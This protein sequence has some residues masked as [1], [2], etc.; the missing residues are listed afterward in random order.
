MQRHIKK[1]RNRLRNLPWCWFLSTISYAS[2]EAFNILHWCMSWVNV[3][4]SKIDFFRSLNFWQVFFFQYIE[5]QSLA[6][7]ASVCSDNTKD[8]CRAGRCSNSSRHCRLRIL[9][10]LH[11]S[12]SVANASTSQ[13]AITIR[14]LRE[15]LLVVVLSIVKL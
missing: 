2:N 13:T 12:V 6:G 7:C 14:Y 11:R 5:L 15:I 4:L 1:C 10:F 3:H 9:T 8:V